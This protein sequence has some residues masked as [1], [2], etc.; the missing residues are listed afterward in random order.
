MF[1][2]S[3]YLIINAIGLLYLAR[4]DHYGLYIIIASFWVAAS[5]IKSLTIPAIWTIVIFMTSFALI[6]IAGIAVN[7]PSSYQL[8]VLFTEIFMAILGVILIKSG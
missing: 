1:T 5:F 8:L 7:A 6:R 2:H 3:I 4:F